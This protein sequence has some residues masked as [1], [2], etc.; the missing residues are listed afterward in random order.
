MFNTFRNHIFFCALT[1][2]VFHFL[3]VVNVKAA[4]GSCDPAAPFYK[5]DDGGRHTLHNKTY[6]L[7]GLQE[8]SDDSAPI[9]AIYVEKEGTVIDASQIIVLGDNSDKISAYGAYVKDGGE[10][11]L[12]DANFNNIPGLRAQNAV[13]NMTRGAFEG[14]SHAIYASG[15]KADIALVSVNIG[16]KPDALNIKSIGILSGFGAMV[17]MSGST[18]TFEEVGSFSSRFG[19]RYL[20]DKMQINGKGKKE[21]DS[22]DDE[23]EEKFIDKFP[24]AFEVFQGGDVHLRDNTIQLTDMHAF[25]IKN[26]SGFADDKGKLVQQYGLSDDFKK[27][28]IQ[29]ERSNVS[30]QGEGTYGLYFHSLGPK[31]L[32]QFLDE[33]EEELSNADTVITGEASVSLTQT[34]LTVPNG[35]AIYSRGSYG[36]EVLSSIELTGNSKISGDLLLKAEKGSFISLIAHDSSLVGG[37]R[38]EDIS[39]V[40]LQLRDGSTWTLRKRKYQD[41]QEPNSTDSSISFLSLFNSTIVF[42]KDSSDD[43][44]TLRIGRKQPYIENEMDKVYNDNGMNEVFSAHGNVQIKLSAFLN[45]EGLFDPQKVDRILIH[46]DVSGTAVIHVQDLSKNSE[47]SVSNE[48][49]DDVKNRSVSI[50]QV[51]GI[52]QQDSFKLAG[53]YVTVNG[54]PYQYNLQ[55]YGPTSPLGRANPSDRLVEGTGEFWDF[56]LESIYINPKPTPSEVIPVEPVTPAPV[57]P[58]PSPLEPS[59]PSESEDPLPT[60]PMPT[61]FTPVP[62]VPS[63]LEPSVP[64]EPEDPSPKDPMPTPSKPDIHSESGIRAVVPQLPTYLFLPNALFY[65]GLMDLTMQNKEL[66]SMGSAS[67]SSWKDDEKTAFFVRGYGGSHHYTSNLSAFEYG[68]GAE[69][70]Y[71]AL[72]AGILLKEI[73]SL[74]SRA[75]FGMMGTY[76]SLS[77][78]P[79]NVAQ[80]KKSTFD[81]WSVAVY[82]SLQHD[83]GFYMD[84]VFSYGLFRGDVLTFA[85][86]KVVA[87]KGKQFSGSLTSGRT[88]ATRYKG[89]IF[90]PQIQIVY[91]HLQFNPA[92]DVDNIDVDLGKFHQWVG[93]VGGRLSK[94]LNVS[95]E[96]RV[97]SFYSKLS[98][99]HSFEDKQFVSFKNDFQLGFFGSFLEAGLGFNARLSSKLS[100][101]GDLTYQ[102]KFKKVGFSGTHFSGGLSYHF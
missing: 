14:S 24:G 22:V 51:S 69:L 46:G 36:G 18:V 1:T 80:S 90:E 77:L 88:F 89:V 57:P 12:T 102:H 82:G 32:V 15:K 45:N 13:I 71:T 39:T 17:R 56:R 38:V 92:Y 52:A 70:D 101:Y 98:Y 76:G 11:N 91:Q 31:Q 20:L 25:L 19:G 54:S 37:T 58:M 55:A 62:P 75:F 87:L 27:T 74:Y 28:K 3:Q 34:T 47:T 35:T 86:G 4:G 23:D 79:Q 94:T 41:L 21:R 96:G 53:N 97:V 42:A 72:E 95:E 59:V 16:I 66:E 2:A 8:D 81:K 29:L 65:A 68:Y 63:P 33:Y 43:Y 64:S 78:Q 44:Q 26:F 7:K 9:A 99:L 93:R 60:D 49:I 73:E 100:L 84:G 83:T 30:V 61:P 50:I 48:R 5:C 40:D 10:L 6:Y 85:R 67:H